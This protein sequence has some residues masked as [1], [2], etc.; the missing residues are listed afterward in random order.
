[1]LFRP[2]LCEQNRG[3]QVQALADKS[4]LSGIRRAIRVQLQD[5]EASPSQSFDCLV[6]VTEACTNALLHGRGAGDARDP[7]V[8]W[9]ITHA[10]ARFLIRDFAPHE[11]AKSKTTPKDKE[12][13]DGG[14]GLKMMRQ[15]MDEVDIKFSPTGTTVA[16]V[17][18]FETQAARS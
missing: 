7:E 11:R 18:Y 10:C 6:A 9:E 16:L 15:L 14:Y 12:K 8:E 13:R 17:K 3:V 1:M 2:P 4:S 5:A